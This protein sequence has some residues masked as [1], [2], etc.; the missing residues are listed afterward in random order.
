MTFGGYSLAAVS[1]L[2]VVLV[3]VII[4]VVVLVLVILVLIV[5]LILVVIHYN[6][7]RFFLLRLCH[8]GSLPRYSGFI[9]RT[10]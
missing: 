8:E 1:V 10:E 5:V 9:L 4:L 2:V 7:L 6:F 3:L